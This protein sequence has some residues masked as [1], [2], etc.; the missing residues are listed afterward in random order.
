M[1]AS[2]EVQPTVATAAIG[3]TGVWSIFV[4]LG[5]PVFGL[6]AIAASGT[7]DASEYVYIGAIGLAVLVAMIVVFALIMRRSR[8]RSG[9]AAGP[10]QWRSRSIGCSGRTRPTSSRS[11]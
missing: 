7:I 1:L 8:S 9:S 3:A 2:Y 10:T 6:M 4:T 5:L 11:W